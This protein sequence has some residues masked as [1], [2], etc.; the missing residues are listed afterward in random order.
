MHYY[1]CTFTVLLYCTTLRVKCRKDCCAY[2][3]ASPVSVTSAQEIYVPG[4]KGSVPTVPCHVSRI[5]QCNGR[6][7][8]SQNCCAYCAAS[9]VS[10]SSVQNID[11]PGPEMSVCAYCAVSCVSM[12]C[13]LCRLPG[14]CLE[15]AGFLI[16]RAQ[17]VCA[18][19]TVPC[20]VFQ[21]GSQSMN[22]ET[23]SSNNGNHN[24]RIRI[25]NIPT[26]NQKTAR[27]ATL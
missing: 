13:L 27:I 1:E 15:C 4:P 6:S 22:N 3:A 11:V 14:V 20:H 8:W 19:G 9:L 24:H 12:L 17:S 26:D 5:K 7:A 21:Q 18:Y 25:K 23:N 2:C 10:V 16:V